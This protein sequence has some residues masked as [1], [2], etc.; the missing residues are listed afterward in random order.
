M[1]L[2]LC[3]FLW[4]YHVRIIESLKQ[5]GVKYF[6]IIDYLNVSSSGGVVQRFMGLPRMQNRGVT[7]I[8]F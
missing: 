7:G 4:W 6:S 8:F 3:V 1:A 5:N 2:F